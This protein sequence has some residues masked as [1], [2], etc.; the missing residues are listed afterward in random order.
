MLIKK[1]ML[2]L[3]VAAVAITGVYCSKRVEIPTTSFPGCFDCF[4]KVQKVAR[5]AGRGIKSS[6]YYI[7]SA[8]DP[9]VIYTPWKMAPNG[10][11]PY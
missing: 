6:D 9:R 1:L 4:A 7:P 8:S 5:G 10:W 3:F 11:I 2:G